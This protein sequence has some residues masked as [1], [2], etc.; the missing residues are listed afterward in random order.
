MGV[1]CCEAAA[2]AADLEDGPAAVGVDAR[3]QHAIGGEV[4]PHVAEDLVAGRLVE[5]VEPRLAAEVGEHGD[6][7]VPAAARHRRSGSG[8]CAPR[9]R[10][11]RWSTCRARGA[12]EVPP[13]DQQLVEIEQRIGQQRGADAG[14]EPIRPVRSR[15]RLPSASDFKQGRAV[16]FELGHGLPVCRARRS[17]PETPFPCRRWPAARPPGRR[18]PAPRSGP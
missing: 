15:P 12:A 16:A 13:H 3:K 2:V 8:S 18:S 7:V 9:S 17:G 10:R 14:Q 6:L 4:Q 11:R 5:P 1:S